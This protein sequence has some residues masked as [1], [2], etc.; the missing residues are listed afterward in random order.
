MAVTGASLPA[1]SDHEEIAD[2]AATF[3]TTRI[4]WLTRRVFRI[5]LVYVASRTIYRVMRPVVRILSSAKNALRAIGRRD[6][7]VPR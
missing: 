7:D 6:I 2:R 1:K 3:A 4:E 5:R